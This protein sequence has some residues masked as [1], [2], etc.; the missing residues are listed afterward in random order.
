M[1]HVTCRRNI[2]LS[3]LNHRIA[4]SMNA[5]PS[6]LHGVDMLR[7]V[8]YGSIKKSEVPATGMVRQSASND[9]AP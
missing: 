4:S 9:T 2:P 6:R 3:R 1:H 5:S 7:A 8:T